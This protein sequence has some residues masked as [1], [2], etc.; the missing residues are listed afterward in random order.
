MEVE[1][2][3]YKMSESKV[4]PEEEM[5]EIK[6]PLMEVETTNYK[7]SESKV[8][9]EEEMPEIKDPLMEEETTNYKMSESKVIPEE[10]MPE[11]K[12]P[13]MEV[14]TTNYKMSESKV[15]PEEEMPEIKDPLMEEESTH[16][17]SESKLIPEGEKVEILHP[18]MEKRNIPHSSTC[19]PDEELPDPPVKDT[20]LTEKIDPSTEDNVD[21]ICR[22][23]NVVKI[24]EEEKDF[25]DQHQ[26]K[27]IRNSIYQLELKQTE[28]RLI[29]NERDL[30]SGR[31]IVEN[32]G[33]L[34]DLHIELEGEA[35]S[36]NHV[37]EVFS[38]DSEESIE[39]RTDILL[40]E[41]IHDSRQ[42]QDI[43]HLRDMIR[44][45]DVGFGSHLRVRRQRGFYQY[46]HHIFTLEANNQSMTVLH[47]A[48][49]LPLNI[50]CDKAII[51]F[52]DFNNTFLNFSRGVELLSWYAIPT[53][54]TLDKINQ[55][56]EE[57]MTL[58]FINYSLT[59]P[60]K[61]NCASLVSYILI[62][63]KDHREV[64][65]FICRHA[66]SGIYLILFVNCICYLISNI[67]Y[68]YDSAA[69]FKAKLTDIFQLFKLN[70][71]EKFY[72]F[73]SCLCII[74]DLVANFVNMLFRKIEKKRKE[75]DENW[76]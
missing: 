32:L 57:V 51:N 9:P 5:P 31:P 20:E 65:E 45:K 48:I 69:K 19:L 38:S 17:M 40:E 70:I 15:I 60:D 25:E 24:H 46:F 54:R 10:E 7:M 75:S 63:E 49:T 50:F 72:S 74:W 62:G 43:D 26:K 39:N 52:S 42:I 41:K 61:M 21:N 14:E 47:L 56:I 58:G 12:D 53:N 22:G 23:F 18:Q 71:S 6:D 27:R 1:T 16:K 2:T 35:C 30:T 11:I 44:N 34:E 64:F 3:N 37:N 29:G 13:L 73:L 67:R 68:F 59:S 76:G 8:I 28:S 66:V 36:E 33:R 55:R 4:I